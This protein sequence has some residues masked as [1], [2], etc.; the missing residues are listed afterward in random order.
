MT[1]ETKPKR[2]ES[3]KFKGYTIDELRYRKALVTLKLEFCKEQIASTMRVF[4][5][6]DTYFGNNKKIKSV[7]DSSMIGRIFKG[8]NYADYIMLGISTFSSIRK[9]I[10]FFK[11]K[12]SRK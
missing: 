6:K 1:S 3:D 11:R 8:L 5:D 10:S 4:A 12:K 2:Q 9:I 7:F